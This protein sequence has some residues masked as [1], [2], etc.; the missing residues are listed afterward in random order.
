MKKVRL[1]SLFGFLIPTILYVPKF[2]LYR[3]YS[4]YNN[5]Q[6]LDSLKLVI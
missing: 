6:F 3:I 1:L 5:I 4:T 2:Y